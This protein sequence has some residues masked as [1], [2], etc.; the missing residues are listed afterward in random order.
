MWVLGA[1]F[2]EERDLPRDVKNI[3]NNWVAGNIS[4]HVAVSERD[5]LKDASGNPMSMAFFGPCSDALD[6]RGRCDWSPVGK[7]VQPRLMPG[8][9]SGGFFR[10]LLGEIGRWIPMAMII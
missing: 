2:R 6:R 7:Q 4:F 10:Q 1:C 5:N 9:Q 3:D 8:A